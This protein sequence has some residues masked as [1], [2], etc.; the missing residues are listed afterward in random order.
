[1]G[2][3]GVATADLIIP[4]G[5]T[6]IVNL[7]ESRYCCFCGSLIPKRKQMWK[8]SDGNYMCIPCKTRLDEDTA[9]GLTFSTDAASVVK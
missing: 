1:M 8:Y 3:W 2:M 7:S 4:Q 9:I 5:N 6:D